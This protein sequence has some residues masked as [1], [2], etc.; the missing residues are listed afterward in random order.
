[1]N[2]IGLAVRNLRRRP[3][4]TLLTI[5]GIGLAVG[6]ALALVALSRSIED[7]T[8]DGVN[9]HGADLTVTQKG[10]PDLFGGFLSEDLSDKLAAVPG[11]ARVAGELFLFAPTER[12]RQVLVSGWTQN[13]YFWKSVPLREGRLPEPG[14]R[15][16]ALVGDLTAEALAKAVG[17]EIELLGEKFRVIG[18]TKYDAMVNRGTVIVPLPDLQDATF[19]RSQVS[20]FYLG[21]QRGLK[22]AELERI[23]QDIAGLG[24]VS[25]SVASELL[26][27]DRNFKVLKAVSLSVSI[28]ALSMGVLNVLN[29][30]LMT[31]QE[32]TR[33]IGI[34]SAIGW[35]DRRIMTSIV[36][37]GVMMSMLGCV[38]GIGVGYLAGMLFPLVPTVGDYIDFKPTLAL[39]VPTLLA[40]LVL[41]ALGSLYPAWRATRMTPAEALQRA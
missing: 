36:L 6:S 11:V 10:A 32:R 15:H 16:I 34:I 39:V 29:T 25:V 5:M 37:E 41:C 28:I 22:P 30:L 21:L 13:S 19:R 27:N 17:S 2:L 20:M 3:M 23:K 38:V 26:Q 31:I 18:I 24:R 33:E 14:E 4:R 8:R 1:M 40:A 12:D 9:E 7:S 35:S